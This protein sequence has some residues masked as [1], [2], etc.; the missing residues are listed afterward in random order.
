VPVADARYTLQLP[1][2]WE[3]KAVWIN[4]PELRPVSVGSNQ[5]QWELKQI[6]EIKHEESM[7]PWKGVAGTMV[8]ALIPPGGAS[9]G[10]LTWS[11]M[12][13]WYTGL[14]QNRRNASPAIKQKV[15]ELTANRPTALGKMQALAE[16]TQKDI[17]YVGMRPFLIA[18]GIAKTKP[19]FSHPCLRNWEL[20]R[21][22]WP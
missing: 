6:P 22:T 12:G 17:R 21:I 13:A 7:P 14:L 2:G 11:E 5:W 8:V 3:Y 18:M 9:H 20:T 10:F 1:P 4:H 19:R 16:F 15:A